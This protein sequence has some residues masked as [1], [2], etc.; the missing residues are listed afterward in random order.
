MAVTISPAT[1]NDAALV[2]AFVRKLAEYENMEHHVTS[3]EGDLRKWLFGE[4]R[5]AEAVLARAGDTPV[6]CA[7]FFP[8]FS[9]Y[10]GRPAIYIEDLIVEPEYRGSG[11]GRALM[12]YLADLARERGCDRLN[13]SVLKWNRKAIG[14]YERLG[15]AVVDDWATY[16]LEVGGGRR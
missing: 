5:V 12:D 3:T 8:I 2:Y 1:E 7:V 11:V 15:A 13:W 16:R 14:F 9:T 10:S 6:G 4:R